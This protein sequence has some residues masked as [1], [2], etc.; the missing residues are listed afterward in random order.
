MFFNKIK[1]KKKSS[2]YLG[3]KKGFCPPS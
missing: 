3:A 2:D 1:Q